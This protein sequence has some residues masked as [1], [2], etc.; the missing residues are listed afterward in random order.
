MIEQRTQRR[1]ERDVFA[2]NGIIYILKFIK[3]H[4]YNTFCF[5]LF[6]SVQFFKAISV[7]ITLWKS[8]PF[9]KS[10]EWYWCYWWLWMVKDDEND[11]TENE[12]GQY[13]NKTKQIKIL[14]HILIII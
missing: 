11:N 4:D 3:L 9:A 5:T 8:S 14:L 2:F 12:I 13:N 7:L 1:I 10:Y 6:Y